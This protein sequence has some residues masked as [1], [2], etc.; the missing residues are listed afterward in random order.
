M[1][2]EK[3]QQFLKSQTSKMAGL[4]SVVTILTALLLGDGC[5]L[6]ADSFFSCL[7][8]IETI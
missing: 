6:Q 4:C 8:G 7:A 5:N 1:H 3:N 2:E